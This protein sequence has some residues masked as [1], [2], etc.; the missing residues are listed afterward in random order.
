MHTLLLAVEIV[1]GISILLGSACWIATLVCAFSFRK[2]AYA[3]VR[4]FEALPS[5]TLLKPVYGL[6]KNLKQNLRTACLQDYPE[7]QV[8][9]SVQRLDDPAI[10]LLNELQQEFGPDRVSVAI[11][12]ARVGLN[13]KINNLAG[14]L[15][16]A[17]HEVIV[18]SDSDVRLRPDYLKTIVAPL[19]DPNVGCVSTFFKASDAASWYERLELLTINADH[20]AIALRAARSKSAISASAPRRRSRKRRCSHWRDRR[21]RRLSRRGQRDGSTHRAHRQKVSRRSVRRRHHGLLNGP[22]HW[23]QKQTYWDQNTR[24]AIPVV[25]AASFVLRIIPLGLVFAVLRGWDGLGLSI[26]V[27]SVAIRLAAAA[28]V[29]GVALRD[30]EGLGSLWLV[31][32]RTCFRCFGSCARSSSVPSFG[33]A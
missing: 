33:A 11:E 1:L 16:H 7:Y 2:R 21:A 30:R 32:A 15:R 6:E 18:I 24:A 19:G 10:S 22:V 20:F 3:G 29:L 8:V 5:I 23:W 26:L 9:Y 27:G 14:A 4:T 12:N 17:R 13:G 25:F 28:A 31:P